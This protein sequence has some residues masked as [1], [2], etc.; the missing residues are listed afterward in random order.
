[1]I[2]ICL[3]LTL[4]VLSLISAN[5]TSARSLEEIRKSG[6]IRIG[7]SPIHPS[8]CS[9]LP[10]GCR[11]N[12]RFSG[13]A[14]EIALAFAQSLGTGIKP[15]FLSVGWDEQFYNEEGKTVREGSYTPA[16]LASGQVDLYPNNLSVNK[17]RKKKFDFVVL[18][19]S[20]RM[21]V[22]HRSQKE[23][24]KK[25][26][27]LAGKTALVEKDTSYHT[28]LQEQ[29]LTVFS[30]HPMIIRLVTTREGL[31]L[32]NDGEANFTVI[33]SDAAIWAIREEYRN[34]EMAFPVGGNDENGWGLRKQDQD[35]QNAVQQFFNRQR[36][37]ENSD[38]NRIWQ[39]YYG[40]SLTE[41]IRLVSA[42][43]E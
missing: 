6:E 18:F 4:L 42:I 32:L 29:N 16:L 20:R 27:D 26:Q 41:F 21:V 31:R 1:M 28:W 39:H 17:W 13:P 7:L 34:L 38:L 40:M 2:Q 5:P 36:A 19:P 9:V 24:M 15:R 14:Y 25:I 8:V 43:P 30:E 33:D 37:D 35:L 10:E 22:V 23:K 11:T 3:L 12:C